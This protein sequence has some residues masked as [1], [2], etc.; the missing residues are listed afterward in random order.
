MCA[1]AA[2]TADGSE[3]PRRRWYSPA[4]LALG[5]ISLYRAARAASPYSHCR[6]LPTCSQ[7]TAEAIERFGFLRGV[8]LGARRISRCHPWAA[9]GYDPVP[10]IKR[11]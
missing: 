1:G 3:G 10:Q 7:Y 2:E 11:V 6:Y 5:L 4:G 9:G 8:W